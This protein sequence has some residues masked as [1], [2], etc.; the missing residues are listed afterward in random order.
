MLN[1]CQVLRLSAA[2]QE[3]PKSSVVNVHGVGPK[4]LE[5]GKR[6]ADGS[7]TGKSTFSKGAYYLG[8]MIWGKGYRELV[9]LLAENKQQLS[10]VELDVYGSG[11]DSHEVRAAAQAHG[12][13][14]TFYQGR[15]HADNALHGYA[16]LPYSLERCS[17]DLNF[18]LWSSKY[19]LLTVNQENS[20]GCGSTH[21]EK[22]F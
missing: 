21:T 18:I 16:S 22:K 19:S 5:I 7:E 14:M 10:N 13:Q 17:R 6:L 12:L 9:D 3:L 11:E 15:D 1:V 4:F 20:E 2:T 8:K